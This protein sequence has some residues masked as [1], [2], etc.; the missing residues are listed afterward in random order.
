MRAHPCHKLRGVKRLCDIIVCPQSQPAD[1]IHCLSAGCDHQNRNIYFIPH[2]TAYLIA[3]AIRQAEEALAQTGLGNLAQAL[4]AAYAALQASLAEYAEG[5]SGGA[6]L[7]F[8]LQNPEF[9]TDGSGWTGTSFTAASSGVAEFYDKTFDT[10][11][12]LKN[13]PAGT[14]RFQCQGFYRDGDYAVAYPAHN[15]GSEQLRA[16]L[17]VNDRSCPFMSLFDDSAP[18]TYT[19][20]TYPDNVWTANSAFNTDGEY[21]DNFVEYTLDE[22][23]DLQVGMRKDT[24]KT[25]DWTCFDNFRLYYYGKGDGIREATDDNNAPVDVY[26][27]SGVKLR[28]N[29][30]PA[31]ATKGLPRG[32]YIVGKKKMLVK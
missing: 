16:V 6:D 11:Q 23:G 20:Y 4:P 5:I 7:T 30:A 10:Y 17:Y 25:H 19:P 27:L 3:A 32:L 12:V 26:T 2:R 21:T 8:L 18:Y 14:Y 24:Y 9:T 15:D 28:E 1:Y 29:A 13:M 22:T 31:Q